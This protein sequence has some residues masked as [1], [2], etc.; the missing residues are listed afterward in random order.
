VTAAPDIGPEMGPEMGRAA[1]GRWELLRSLGAV[2]DSP[3]AARCVGPAL[4]LDPLS[5]AEHTE[6][7]VLNCPPYAGIYLGPHGAIGGEGADRVAGFWRAIGI[8]PP[9]EPDHLAALLGLYARLGE[10]AAGARR[11]AT[12]AALARSQAVLFWEHL[13]PWLPGYLDAVADL[14]VPSLTTW[15]DLVR[16]AIAAEY[17]AKP[18]CPRQPLALR[19]AP[20]A[21]V[22]EAEPAAVPEAEPAAVP[23][24]EPAAV[25]AAEPAAVPAA[26]P[27]AVPEAGPV[28]GPRDL[29]ELVTIPVR[30]G[31]ILTRRRLAEGAGRAGV[32]F[33][34]G[35]RRFA[36]RAMLEQ[37]PRA[38]V[39]WL[40]G[41][42]DRWQQR[43]RDRAPRDE[44]TGWWAARAARTA[45]V[46][47]DYAG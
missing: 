43:H 13:W 1:A 36:L 40:A 32:G 41:E 35:E 25:P 38:T 18:P 42:A 4:G 46:L 16:R 10:A 37:D 21:A 14:A 3:A 5:D 30:S 34:I 20:P 39:A 29:V 2:S 19:A 7:F 26:E 23:E 8:T 22:P 12:A 47:R 33:R 45:Q 11:P 31:L 15:T 28:A 44:V 27:A 6:A 24:A 17:R 9:A